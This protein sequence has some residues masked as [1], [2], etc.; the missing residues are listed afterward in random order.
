VSTT[1]LAIGIL[2]VAA[3]AVVVFLL[4]SANRRR[5][6]IEDV[7]PALR[8]A[9]SDEQLETSVFERYQA[10]GLVMTLFFALFF[11]VYYFNESGRLNDETQEF[12][13]ASVVRGGE[14]YANLCSVCHGPEGKGGAAPS[15][16]GEGTW[17]APDLTTMV[18]RYDDNPNIKDIEFFIRSTI[19]RGRPGTPMPTWGAAFGGSLN[20]Q[21]VDDLT[22]WILANQVE[23]EAE[24]IAYESGAEVYLAN[25]ARC[26]GESLEGIVGPALLGVTQRHSP[27]TLA[28]IIRNGIIMPVGASMPPWQNGWMYEDARLS[29]EAIQ[30]LITFLQSQSEEPLEDEESEPEPQATEA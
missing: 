19:D 22:N 6:A 3:V 14:E 29:D 18:S 28:G 26:H 20:D 27:E 25:C 2:A 30:Q 5:K 9:Y 21:Q 16:Y 15:P 10:W 13:V 1:T 11:P 7:P 8:P 23:A 24:E 12:F 17:P 4:A